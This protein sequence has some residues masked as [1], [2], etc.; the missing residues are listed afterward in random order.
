MKCIKCGEE[1]ITYTIIIKGKKEQVCD[2][3]YDNMGSV[4]E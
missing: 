2:N 1:G 4:D 3:C